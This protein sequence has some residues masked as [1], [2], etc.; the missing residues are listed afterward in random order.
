MNSVSTEHS[1]LFEAI[2]ED[3]FKSK[4][5]ETLN[6]MQ[7]IPSSANSKDERV[8]MDCFLAKKP[9][10]HQISQSSKILDI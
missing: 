2:N 7:D 1:K 6:G 10:F 3:E 9:E 4:L 5:E 8:D